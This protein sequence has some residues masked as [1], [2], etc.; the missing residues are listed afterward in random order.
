M[1]CG[2]G[3][4]RER[5]RW[6]SRV[7]IYFSPTTQTPTLMKKTGY[8]WMLAFFC[9]TPAGFAQDA[10]TTYDAAPED[11]ASIDAIIKASYDV[12]SGAAGEARDWDV[13]P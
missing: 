12:I 1:W 4:H 6:F 3:G 13:S 8:C 2:S 9:I 7:G 11:A 10:A 5:R